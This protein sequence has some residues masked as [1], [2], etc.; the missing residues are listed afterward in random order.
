MEELNL[1]R[2]EKIAESLLFAAGEPVSLDSIARVLGQNPSTARKIVGQLQDY[3]DREERGMQILEI[4]NSFQMTSR[5][6]YY[7][8]I[9]L[10]DRKS[11]V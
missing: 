10:L 11:V 1:K 4:E 3:Y 9:K 7:S 5:P 6:D 2:L 8:Y